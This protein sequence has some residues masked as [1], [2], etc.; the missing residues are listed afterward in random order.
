[1]AFEWEKSTT[2]DV[3]L[4]NADLFT[5]ILQNYLESEA[6]IVARWLDC[7]LGVSE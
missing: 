4:M 1:M 2:S 5:F 6:R 3:L 7:C